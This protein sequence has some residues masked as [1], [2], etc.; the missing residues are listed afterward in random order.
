VVSKG[1]FHGK[2]SP[3]QGQS[4]RERYLS[5][6]MSGKKYAEFIISQPNGDR[7]LLESANRVR[8]INEK[9]ESE[10]VFEARG[11]MGDI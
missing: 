8:V 6:K 5:G 9:L 1:S 2:E 3:E 11:Q 4:V 10:K 7:V